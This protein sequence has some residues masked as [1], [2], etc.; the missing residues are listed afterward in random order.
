MTSTFEA[1]RQFLYERSGP[2]FGE[3]SN[4]G[5]D[6]DEVILTGHRKEVDIPADRCG[7]DS[8]RGVR[9]NSTSYERTSQA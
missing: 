8:Q 7:L 6:P 4:N 5:P 2:S 3:V 9:R 1:L